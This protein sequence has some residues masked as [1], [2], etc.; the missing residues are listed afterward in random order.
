MEIIPSIDIID[1]RVVRLVKGNPKTV[2][3]YSDDPISIA[4]QWNIDGADA[5]H[6]VDLDAAFSIKNNL[7]FISR[8]AHAVN[9]PIQVGGGIRETK[10]IKNIFDMG[11]S[12]IVLGTIAFTNR[13]LLN[14]LI[15][16]YGNDKVVVA[17][18]HIAGRVMVKGWISSTGLYL[19][20]AF[21]IFREMNVKMFLVTSIER[22]GTLEG[23]DLKNLINLCKYNDVDIFLSGG[24]SSVTDLIQLRNLHIKGVI[25]GRAL[26]EKCFT[27]KEAR[28]VFK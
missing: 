9:I 1:G 22:D 27:L 11:V 19:E 18:D 24:I 20:E 14:S 6:I 28:S 4:K 16:E 7:P 15:N 3:I 21:K 8:I 5:I 17:L 10:Y 2:K 26:Y 13:Y 12:R 23:P 25:I